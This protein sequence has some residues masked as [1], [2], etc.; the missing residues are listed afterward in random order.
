MTEDLFRR[1][2]YTVNGPEPVHDRDLDMTGYPR[3]VDN[4]QKTA[5]QPELEGL[6]ALER[7]LTSDSGNDLGKSIRDWFQEHVS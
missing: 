6:E 5:L 2:G 4:L 7:R 1:L 3:R